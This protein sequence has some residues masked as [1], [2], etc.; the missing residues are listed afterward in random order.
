MAQ[1]VL[2]RFRNSFRLQQV[3]NTLVRYGSDTMFDRGSFGDWRRW[4]QE[5]LWDS[6]VPLESLS[7][8]VKVRLML[9]ELG[10]TYVKVGQIASSRGG[11][12][13][14]EW[15]AELSKL[16]S[17]VKPFAYEDVRARVIQELGGPPE[18]IFERFDPTPLAA[19]SLAQAHRASLPGGQEVIV[20]VQR[21]DIESQVKAD[22]A[23]MGNAARVA[24]QR[25]PMAR[26]IGARGIVR[27]FGSHVIDEMD[28]T[29][30][31]FNAYRL[32][33]NLNH[34]PGIHV[35][36]V[37]PD[38]ST[39]RVVTM[40]FIP[41][42]KSDKAEAIDEWGLD[43]AYLATSAARGAVKMLLVDGFFHADPHPGNVLITPDDGG[44]INFIDLGMVGELTLQ[45]RAN[46]IQLLLL[47]QQK[48]VTGMGQSLLTLSEP[49]RRHVDE[50]AFYRDFERRMSRFFMPGRSSQFVGVIPEAM[51]VL[52]DNGYRLDPQLTLGIKA[53]TQA[54]A[55]AQVLVPDDPDFDFIGTGVEIT[56]DLLLEEVTTE[57]IADAIKGQA[58]F[59]LRELAGEL[60]SLQE[61]TLKWID[62]YR[63]GR[64]EVY[65]DTSGLEQQMETVRSTTRILTI[66]VIISGV[67][68]G[69]AIAASITQSTDIAGFLSDFALVFYTAAAIAAAIIVLVLV[70]RWRRAEKEAAEEEEWRR[71]LRR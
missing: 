33:E 52:R 38:Y 32:G 56:K 36:Y 65:V 58:T 12:L 5:K 63:K 8:P 60:P 48:D 1:T 45:K 24:E 3:Y 42:V 66:G 11:T 57:K 61:A 23:I 62:Q 30:E 34:L 50:K 41:G 18:E 44:K 7:T 26:E 21:P 6:P 25:S 70:L 17:D 20:K 55:I 13:P 10:P 37:Y 64:L 22:I 46:L 2:D 16:H 28:Y 14:L 35:P 69:S 31:A 67:V 47:F 51:E 68:I 40:E 19:A 39:K 29:I 49:I 9:Q 4:W 71:R 59:M 54:G 53:L 15:E 43:R 27:E